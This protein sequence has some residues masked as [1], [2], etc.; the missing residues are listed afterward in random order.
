[1][2]FFKTSKKKEDVQTSGNSGYITQSGCYPVNVIVPFVSVSK[3]GSTSVD[4]FIQHLDQKQVMYGNLRVTNNDGSPNK[5]GAKVFNQLMIIA[6]LEEVDEPVDAELPIGKDGKDVDVSILEDLADMD[7]MMRVQMEYSVYNGNIQEKKIIKAFYR[8]EDNA[9]A[10]EIVNEES[11]GTQ[12]DK[13]SKYFD[14][15]TYKDGL[16]AELIATWISDGRPKGTGGN[17]SSAAASSAPA[18]KPAFGKKKSF[19]SK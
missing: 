16:D 13:D 6:D 7:V 19:G 14:N 12:F 18:K 11:F 5:I 9:S 17:S 8:A 10:E 15:V 1:M 3:G 4:L 2:S